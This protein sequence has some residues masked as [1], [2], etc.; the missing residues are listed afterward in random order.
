MKWI[1][2]P[3]V[4]LLVASTPAFATLQ[5]SADINGTVISCADQQVSCD[6]NLAPGILS[7][8]DQTINGVSVL[9]SAQ[10]QTI[11]P[12]NS[13]NTASF[14]ITNTNA[15]SV[16][17]TIA[18][19]GTDFV[20]PVSSF[21]AAGSGTWQSADGSTATL[22]FYGDTANGQGAD[23]PTDLPG[24]QLATLTANAVGI[25]D[26][27][28]QSFSGAFVDT[29]LY[30]MSLGTTGTLTAGGSLVGRA[31]TIV[32]AQ[33]IPEPGSLL[34]LGTALF[35]FGWLYRRRNAAPDAA[36]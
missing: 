14:Q 34:L 6:T 1:S 9:G 27:F 2:P 16:P 17:I 12:L 7:I 29:D 22:T 24:T 23:N 36:W 18:I 11:G 5:I 13:L 30:S 35:G 26:S 31:Q 25:T 32:T 8:A 19:S 4:A 21:S 33:E 3:V 15:V 20:G 10:T 28:N